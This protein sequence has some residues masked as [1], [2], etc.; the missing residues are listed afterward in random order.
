LIYL[1]RFDGIANVFVWEAT[2]I[3]PILIFDVCVGLK[4]AI[5]E[6]KIDLPSSL[7]TNS[8]GSIY[9]FIVPSSYNS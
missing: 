7:K 5:E 3:P 6:G 1:E 4:V 8:G 9:P 2:L